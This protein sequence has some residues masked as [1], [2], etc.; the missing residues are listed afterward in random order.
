MTLVIE[1]PDSNT[2]YFLCFRHGSQTFKNTPTSADDVIFYGKGRE[3]IKRQSEEPI[4]REEMQTYINIAVKRAIE[5]KS[6]SK[7]Q[8]ERAQQKHIQQQGGMMM[9]GREGIREIMMHQEIREPRNIFL[10]KKGQLRGIIWQQLNEMIRYYIVDKVKGKGKYIT[11]EIEH[12][13][14]SYHEMILGDIE[15]SLSDELYLDIDRFIADINRSATALYGKLFVELERMSALD[16]DF[17]SETEINELNV[18][19]KTAVDMCGRAIAAC[20]MQV[21]SPPQPRQTSE[22]QIKETGTHV[23]KKKADTVRPVDT[24]TLR[25]RTER[26]SVQIQ[27]ERHQ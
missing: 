16:K 3:E 14:A 22:R 26:V 27:K 4:S 6:D 24:E 9:I 20:A 1:W 17:L 18:R 21:L 13:I 19:N 8:A 7:W 5:G 25:L 23:P 11:Q 12:L 2:L 15:R 10:V